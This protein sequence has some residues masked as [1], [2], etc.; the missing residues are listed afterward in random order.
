MQGLREFRTL[1]FR[2]LV[3]EVSSTTRARDL[4]KAE[5]YASA[6]VAA[7]WILD[8]DGRRLETCDVPRP[9]GT[10]ASLQ[11]LDE[12]DAVTLPESPQPLTVHEPRPA[13]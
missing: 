1:R 12:H 5:I 13:P 4:R 7:S 2:L 11:I 10:C 9:D 3:V 8:G 6:G